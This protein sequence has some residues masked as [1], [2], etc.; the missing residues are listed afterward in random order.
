MS[1]QDIIS[2][3]KRVVDSPQ[4]AVILKKLLLAILVLLVLGLCFI[5]GVVFASTKSLKSSPIEVVYPLLVTTIET[6]P[7]HSTVGN[8]PVQLQK[9][10][11]PVNTS[12]QYKNSF[13]GSKNSKLYYSPECTG[14]RRIKEENRVYFTTSKQAQEAGRT[15][16]KSCSK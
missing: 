7:E 9:K 2:K 13:V 12:S 6:V 14:S 15:L 10:T 11:T 16:A 4:F 1:I 3:I 8:K 5:A